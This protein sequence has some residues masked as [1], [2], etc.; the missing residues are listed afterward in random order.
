[1][2]K[3]YPGLGPAPEGPKIPDQPRSGGRVMHCVRGVVSLS[4][5]NVLLDEVDKDLERRG[6]RFARFAD[7]CNVYVRSWRAGERVLQSLRRLYAKLHLKVNESK[8]AGDTV[9]GRRF[10]E[11]CLRRGAGT[12]VKIAVA[13]K[14]VARFKQRV[15]E[16]TCRSG[17]RT[18][19]AV[20]SGVEVL[21][22]PCRDADDV[23][24]PKLMDTSSTPGGPAQALATRPHNLQWSAPLGASH[25]F[26]ATGGRW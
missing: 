19:E 23:Q 6:R 11:Y 16:T 3:R 2:A 26:A 5:A 20:S 22:S 1:M 14:A 15:R 4:L 12:V 13:P 17:G 7:D 8:T 25:E 21:F 9:F 18:D 10:L 24:G